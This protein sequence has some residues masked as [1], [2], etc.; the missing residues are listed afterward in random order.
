MKNEVTSKTRHLLRERSRGLCE[1]GLYQYG[2]TGIGVHIHH[3]KYR[4]RGGSHDPINLAHLCFN[5]HSAIHTH[6]KGTGKWRTPRW[7]KEGESEDEP[8]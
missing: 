8:M 4:S 6:K 2:C 7:A 1:A 5:C 3:K